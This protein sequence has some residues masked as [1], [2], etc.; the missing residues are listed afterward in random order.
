MNVPVKR[1]NDGTTNY[2]PMCVL[3]S[4]FLNSAIEVKNTLGGIQKGSTLQKNTSLQT[5]INKLLAIEGTDLEQEIANKVDK[6]PGKGLST[7]DFT[8]ELKQR[9]QLAITEHQDISGKVDKEE[10]KRLTT[11]DFTDVYKNKLINALTEHQDISGKVDKIEGM[12]LSTNDFTDALKAKLVA[13][14]P[15]IAY[16][17]TEL[18]TLISGKLSIG[19]IQW[20]LSET[21]IYPV[22]SRVLYNKITALTTKDTE[23]ETSLNSL[24][25]MVTELDSNKVDK[26]TGKGLST[27]DFTTDL[28]NK[29]NDSVAKF[30]NTDTADI[31][32]FD[33]MKETLKTILIKMGMKPTNITE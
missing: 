26:V 27:N 22:Q 24:T 7:N 2:F 14:S 16:D 12:G 1:L 28:L 29:V 30:S 23:L 17:D 20:T 6:I 31:S 21:S 25:T 10:G 15:T 5:V 4:V 19:D 18:R 33:G 32:S 3:D 9:L 13:L 8:T 11:N